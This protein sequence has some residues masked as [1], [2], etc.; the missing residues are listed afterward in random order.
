MISSL[1]TGL[2]LDESTCSQAL[3]ADAVKGLTL[4]DSSAEFWHVFL[5]GLADNVVFK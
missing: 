3:T 2:F 1:N 4:A 5:E